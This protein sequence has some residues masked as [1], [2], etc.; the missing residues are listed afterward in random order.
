LSLETL[1][2]T[3]FPGLDPELAT[4][5]L[6]N[7]V[8][9]SVKEAISESGG[10]CMSDRDN[11][12]TEDSEEVAML[13]GEIGRLSSLLNT[14]MEGVSGA[15]KGGM[16]TLGERA[17]QR[18]M[19]GYDDAHDD[20]HDDFSLSSAAI[21]YVMDARLRGTTG[22]GFTET[23]PSDW[24]WDVND[25]KPKTIRQA[26]VVAAALIIAEIDHLDR[27]ENARVSD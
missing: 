21:A 13:R 24:P 11:S 16:D 8:R 1:I 27:I 25:W 2:R 6:A 7:L 19:E 4:A 5:A 23:P 22:H 15:S 12:A 18:R 14:H 26:L 9:S 20:A 17:R 10:I 3:A